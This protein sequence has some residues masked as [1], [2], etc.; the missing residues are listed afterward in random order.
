M[1]REVTY[2]PSVPANGESLTIQNIET[3]GSS[4]AIGSRRSGASAAVKVSPISTSAKPATAT[5]SPAAASSI[6]ARFRPS[7]ARQLRDAA[8][9]VRAV[10]EDEDDVGVLADPCRAA[11]GRRRGGRRIRCSRWR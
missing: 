3:V 1:L 2:L 4:M 5:I 11:R 6:S 10:A 8:L 7:N 9:L